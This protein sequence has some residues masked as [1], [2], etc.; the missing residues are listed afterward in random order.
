MYDFLS[1]GVVDSSTATPQGDHREMTDGPNLQGD[2]LQPSTP[3]VTGM[4]CY[5]LFVQIL[6]RFIDLYA[7]YA[8][9]II[10]SESS[11]GISLY[12]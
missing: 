12:K 11:P 3:D 5:N 8:F 10:D 1:S 9:K 7:Q 2:D 6:V 4:S